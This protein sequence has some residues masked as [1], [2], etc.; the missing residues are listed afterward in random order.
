MVS[1]DNVVNMVDGEELAFVIKTLAAT[2]SITI[3]RKRFEAKYGR[4]VSA[5]HIEKVQNKYQEKISAK[6]AEYNTDDSLQKWGGLSRRAR[7]EILLEVVDL[8]LQEQ[9]VG[10]Y[11]KVDENTGEKLTMPIIKR[12]LNSVLVA[13]RA[14][15]EEDINYQELELKKEKAKGGSDE[16]ESYEVDDGIA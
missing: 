4:K 16:D 14:L 2:A 10:T 9:V 12:D 3:T 15:K 1:K 13:L 11:S 6:A 8:G 7:V 5:N